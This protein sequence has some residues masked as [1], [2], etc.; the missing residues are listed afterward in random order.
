MQKLDQYLLKN[1]FREELISSLPAKELGLI[2]VIPAYDEDDLIG[3]VS[4]LQNCELPHCAVEVVV[5]FNASELAPSSVLKCNEIAKEKVE[6]WYASLESPKF[7]LFCLEE[8]A[9]PK[10]HAGVGLARKIGMD[11]ATRRFNKIHR[12]NGLIVCFDA[13]SGCQTN[14]LVEIE[15]HFELNTSSGAC[16]IH[17]EH[18]IIGD[19]FPLAIYKGIE[20]YELHLRYYKNGLAYANLPFAFHTIGSSMVVKTI[21][22][23]EQGGMNRR[24]AGE[25]F[26]FLQKFIDVGVLTELNSTMVIPSPRPSHRVPFGTGRAIQ[27]MMDRERDI[28][29]SYAFDCFE[30][31]KECFKNTGRFY[32]STDL[33]HEALLA[34][35]GAQQW[36]EKLTEIR[37]QST[38]KDRFEKRFFQWF[39]AFQTLKFIHFLRDNYFN[40]KTFI[41]EHSS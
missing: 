28:H 27:E 20:Q 9:L 29:K 2:V 11:E 10:K 25:D 40:N 23:C 39:N 37:S 31:L 24:K 12:S 8:N 4:S 22:Y 13:D 35:I 38:S 7:R 19:D 16:S 17:F 1:A 14:Y 15:K 26:Y 34:F 18:P 32:K 6:N 5:V 41:H 21:S 33:A 3:S 36:E 30:V